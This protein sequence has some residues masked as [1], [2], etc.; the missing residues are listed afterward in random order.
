LNFQRAGKQNLWLIPMDEFVKLNIP[1]IINLSGE[2]R[3]ALTL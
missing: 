3:A 2:I 1:A